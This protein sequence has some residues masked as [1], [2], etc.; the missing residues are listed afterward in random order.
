MGFWPGT[1]EEVSHIPY[2]SRGLER[3]VRDGKGGV[4]Y[5]GFHNSEIVCKLDKC[6]GAKDSAMSLREEVVGTACALSRS[7][8]VA[9]NVNR[10]SVK[11][12][13]K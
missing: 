13:R 5:P 6:T 1:L 3:L 12:K 4:R 10:K 9:G 11:G 8:E 2:A 7:W